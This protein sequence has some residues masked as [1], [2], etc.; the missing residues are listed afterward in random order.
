[1][2]RVYSTAVVSQGEGSYS[3]S[4][5]RRDFLAEFKGLAVT[6]EYN[7][8]GFRCV[9]TSIYSAPGKGIRSHMLK[10]RVSPL[11]RRTLGWHRTPPISFFYSEACTTQKPGAGMVQRSAHWWW[12]LARKTLIDT[13]TASHHARMHPA[14]PNRGYVR[15]RDPASHEIPCRLSEREPEGWGGGG[16][17]LEEKLKCDSPT[18]CT[19]CGDRSLDPAIHYTH[20]KSPPGL[21]CTHTQSAKSTIDS[22]QPTVSRLVL[23]ALQTVHGDNV[24]RIEVVTRRAF[25]CG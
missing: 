19:A 9:G 3:H 2:R 10:I 24:M 13:N 15:N 7:Y 16:L 20:H 1:M 18:S 17:C 25:P 21:P 6:H 22:A 12:V 11:P 14:H 23:R 5:L 4:W 8:S